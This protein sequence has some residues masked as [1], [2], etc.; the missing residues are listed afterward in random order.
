MCSVKCSQP[1]YENRTTD[2]ADDDE[3][4]LGARSVVEVERGDRGEDV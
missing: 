3:Q 4:Y 2:D 1:Q